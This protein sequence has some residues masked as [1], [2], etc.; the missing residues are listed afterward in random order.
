VHPWYLLAPATGTN[1][2]V[3]TYTGSATQISAGSVSLT[4]AAQ[5][6]PVSGCATATAS[7]NAPS[8]A[9]TS[10][11]GSLVL[12]G[13]VFGTTGLGNS[14][15]GTGQT[16]R[17]NKEQTNHTLFGSTEAGATSVTMSWAVASSN[18]WVQIGFSIAPAASSPQRPRRPPSTK[19]SG[20]RDAGPGGGWA[21]SGRWLLGLLP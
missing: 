18:P 19:P 1:N 12:D 5:T 7:S 14:K 3:I 4:G 6:T 15:E 11:R 13:V 20:A 16:E 17:F 10:A 8:V 9:V 2:V 21:M